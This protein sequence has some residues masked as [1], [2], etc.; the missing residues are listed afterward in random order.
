MF[1]GMRQYLSLSNLWK[2]MALGFVITMMAVPRIL[3]GRMDPYVFVPAA[4]FATTL[5]AGAGTAW[6][7]YGGMCGMFPNKRRLLAGMAIACMLAALLIPV[8]L[9]WIDPAFLTALRCLGDSELIRLRFPP[10]IA[11]RLALV[12]WVAGFET[13]FF[14]V[15]AMSFFARL[16]GN[17]WIAVTAV[18]AFRM[19]VT[20]KFMAQ[21]GIVDSTSILMAA[22]A[23]SAALSCALYARTGLPASMVF[24]AVYNLHLFSYPVE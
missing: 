17:Q 9:L 12:L 3:Q 15:G 19:F 23:V 20:S 7:K 22:A 10:T 24:A 11:G 2:A 13:L 4:F 18:C 8:Q 14:Q 5:L 1:Y 21:Y 16:G 6:E